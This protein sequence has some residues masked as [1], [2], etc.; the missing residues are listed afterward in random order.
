MGIKVSKINRI[1]C[2][3]CAGARAG[4][5]VIGW[6]GPGK[7]DGVSVVARASLLGPERERWRLL[8]RLEGQG[9]PAILSL[10][11]AT[12]VSLHGHT[13]LATGIWVCQS[14]LLQRP[15]SL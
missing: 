1:W 5:A 4:K 8:Q 12:C 14:W 2:P 13:A 9:G 15:S 11:A 6:V 3:H 7:G 10:T